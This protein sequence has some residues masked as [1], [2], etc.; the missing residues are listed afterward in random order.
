MQSIITKV[1]IKE[2]LSTRLLLFTI[3]FVIVAE[4]LI[5]APSIANFRV[6][7][8]EQKLA[9]SNIAI[10]VVEAAPDYIVSR[11][12]ADELLSSTETYGI[13]RRI[14]NENQQILMRTDPFHIEQRFDMRNISWGQSVKDAFASLS[15][16][17]EIS[18]LIEITGNANGESNDEIIIVFDEN[19]TK[20]RN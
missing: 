7:W 14:D 3:I 12:L 18:Y 11:L 9:E 16:I 20:N 8:I 4:I 1:S 19:V 13:A 6:T 10:L 15:R 5:Y 2:S 17:Q